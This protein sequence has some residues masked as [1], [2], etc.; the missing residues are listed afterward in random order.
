M[1]VNIHYTPQQLDADTLERLFVNREKQL[2]QIIKCISNAGEFG[3]L[4]HTHIVG[5]R[6]S[7]KTYLV[8]MAYNEAK[9]NEN[10]GKQY[11][12]SLLPEE[13]FEITSYKTL[14]ESIDENR[15]LPYLYETS[16]DS[17]SSYVNSPRE[18]MVTIA[19][20][21]N[22]DQVLND[23]GDEGQKRLRAYI[24]R[25]RNLLLITTA[26]QLSE[27]SFD[28]SMPFYGFFDTINLTA[29]NTEQ[30]TRMLIRQAE[31]NG[32]TALS[33][34][35]QEPGTQARLAALVQVTGGLPRIWSFFSFGLAD[36][37]LSDMLGLM[38]EKLDL[39]TPQYQE[40]MKRLSI[41]ERR[42]V[43]ALINN[44]GAMTVKM[45]AEKTG[46]E[47]KSL[48]TTLRLLPAGWI[49]SRGGYLM[50]YVDKRNTYYQLAEPIYRIV[51]QLK[52]AKGKPVKT[53]VDFLSTWFSLNELEQY[54]FG[55]SKNGS[56]FFDMDF[57]NNGNQRMDGF[58]APYIFEAM[59][60]SRSPLNRFREYML[61]FYEYDDSEN[62]YPAKAD[63][64]LIN[65][66]RKVE[67]ALKALLETG[68]ADMILD[69]PVGIANIIEEKLQ[70]SSCAYMQIEIAL[71][72][73]R[74]G[75]S[76]EFLRY[77][78]TAISTRG[79]EEGISMRPEEEKTAQIIIAC[80][81]LLHGHESAG[82]HT[83][84][85]AFSLGNFELTK[86]QWAII[87][88]TVN[89]PTYP[90][91]F[92]VITE[93]LSCSAPHIPDSDLP[94]FIKLCVKKL[95]YRPG[96]IT[97]LTALAKRIHKNGNF[98]FV[99]IDDF[100]KIISDRFD[101]K[102]KRWLGVFYEIA[103]F[104]I[105]SGNLK[106]AK[107]EL[108]DIL[109]RLKEFPEY[110]F[111]DQLDI[112]CAYA[113]TLYCLNNRS[114]AVRYLS[115][116]VDEAVKNFGNNHP[117]TL[118]FRG[119]LLLYSED[120]KKIDINIIDYEEF[121]NDCIRLFGAEN[122]LT[123]QYRRSLAHW[124]G[125]ALLSTVQ[126]AF[127]P[128]E[129][130]E[131]IYAPIFCDYKKYS[132]KDD[133]GLLYAQ[134]E[135]ANQIYKAGD[136]KRAGIYYC[137]IIDKHIL[138]YGPD[139]AR[140]AAY[141][142][143]IRKC[144]INSD[145]EKEPVDDKYIYDNNYELIDMWIRYKRIVQCNANRSN[146]MNSM[147]YT[148]NEASKILTFNGS[149][150]IS[151]IS[152]YIEQYVFNNDYLNEAGLEK[153]T[154]N[155]KNMFIISIF[156]DF[157]LRV[158]FAF[159][160]IMS[161]ALHN[162][163]FSFYEQN[164]EELKSWRKQ[165]ISDFDSFNEYNDYLYSSPLMFNDQWCYYVIYIKWMQYKNPNNAK[166]ITNEYLNLKKLICENADKIL[167]AN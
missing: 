138:I 81:R 44:E 24:E 130:I 153:L 139:R 85:Y 96:Y 7:G 144:K 105:K 59:N 39:L 1:N 101:R 51:S 92:K 30:I 112:K 148:V 167:A 90:I 22:F 28:Q 143:R 86:K 128:G 126:G 111:R 159:F 150:N 161:E 119:N 70:T 103:N 75:G 127:I 37:N 121:V 145:Y 20:I 97:L 108:A 82:L 137:E 117:Y 45:L 4:A 146:V 10:Y 94:D 56:F 134:I 36:G 133:L 110:N 107:N 118:K 17:D 38:L 69:L 152:L 11:L 47:Q 123:L 40:M 35:L 73:V 14:M 158:S 80:I 76:D 68:S 160:K 95:S 54:P 114:D 64:D 89:C 71:L 163:F 142:D 65:E 155:E 5:P 60:I 52:K 84:E 49:T 3:A 72:A 32:N 26:Q 33:L 87:E 157:I 162:E 41:N 151:T 13:S 149:K 98:S 50:R 93:L 83:L 15:E 106:I 120:N 57:H 12:L 2:N 43:M 8:L 42:A 27:K 104:K 124:Q 147:A 78:L 29:F 18:N 125:E 115:E 88:S 166:I 19:F 122:Y 100:L 74:I 116:I 21:E 129:Q 55:K 99:A 67:D 132:Y 136:W 9:K 31:V 62:T 66:F 79:R 25:N 164:S 53:V 135:C 154:N 91:R 23:L 77:A 109:Q 131:E 46:I 48:S 165:C 141:Y 63:D 6:G 156:I 113:I 102:D 16:E 61:S 58:L 140:I 34:R